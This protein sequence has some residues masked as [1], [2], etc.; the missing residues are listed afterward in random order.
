MPKKIN[1]TVQNPLKGLYI[2]GLQFGGRRYKEQTNQRAVVKK[3]SIFCVHFIDI[4]PV[5]AASL[6]ERFLL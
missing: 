2:D 1:Q 3:R 5:L 6:P 4:R